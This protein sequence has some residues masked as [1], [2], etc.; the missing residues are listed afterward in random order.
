MNYEHYLFVLEKVGAVVKPEV[1][2]NGLKSSYREANP[3]ATPYEAAV[4]SSDALFDVQFAV[5]PEWVHGP[6]VQVGDII[7]LETEFLKVVSLEPGEVRTLS[8]ENSV[9]P[10]FYPPSERGFSRIGWST[11]PCLTIV[12]SEEFHRV[13]VWYAGVRLGDS[14]IEGRKDIS[15]GKRLSVHFELRRLISTLLENP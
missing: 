2:F 4:A 14:L 3:R 11:N 6:K 10:R 5:K 8:L 1:V 12:P 15:F 7:L 13:V 9:L